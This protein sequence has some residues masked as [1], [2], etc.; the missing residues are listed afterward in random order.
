[1]LL[2]FLMI[3]GGGQHCGFHAVVYSIHDSIELLNIAYS[4]VSFDDGGVYVGG[5]ESKTDKV[6]FLKQNFQ[7]GYESIPKED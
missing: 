3:F 5:G 2:S 1:M 6:P 4:E 7:M